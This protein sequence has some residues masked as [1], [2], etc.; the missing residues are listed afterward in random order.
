MSYIAYN[1]IT[2]EILAVAPSIASALRHARLH[3]TPD[4]IVNTATA[5]DALAAAIA[6][7]AARHWGF[8]TDGVACLPVEFGRAA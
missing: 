3:A 1:A 5:S 4:V 7:G 6:A 8:D 2:L